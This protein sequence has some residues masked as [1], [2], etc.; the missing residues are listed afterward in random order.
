CS[1][2]SS[3]PACSCSSASSNPARHRRAEKVR[4]PCNGGAA[5]PGAGRLIDP[6][7]SAPRVGGSTPRRGGRRQTSPRQRCATSLGYRLLQILALLAAL[8]AQLLQ[9]SQVLARLG[10]LARLHVELAQVFERA[11]VVGIELERLA[12]EGVGLFAVTALAQ[13]EPE[14]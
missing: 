8:R 12:V 7:V 4:R 2:C 10:H 6:A 1:F 5:R 9:Q 3:P 11:L 13:A 14:Q